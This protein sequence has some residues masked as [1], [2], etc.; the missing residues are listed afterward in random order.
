M[1]PAKY[2]DWLTL[3][4]YVDLLRRTRVT[5]FGVGGSSQMISNKVKTVYLT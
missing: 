2:G 4:V 5:T 1:M 3:S